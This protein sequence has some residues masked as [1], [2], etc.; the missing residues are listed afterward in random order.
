MSGPEITGFQLRSVKDVLLIEALK[1]LEAFEY[2][3][4]HPGEEVPIPSNSKNDLKNLIE[5]IKV[6]LA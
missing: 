3:H 1:Y 5:R 6:N 2:S 4:T